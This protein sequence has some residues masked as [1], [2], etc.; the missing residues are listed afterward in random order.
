[1]SMSIERHEKP[2]VSKRFPSSASR[3]WPPILGLADITKPCAVP[4]EP[5]A[6]AHFLHPIKDFM[7]SLDSQA[8]LISI[9]VMMDDLTAGIGW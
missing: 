7:K 3:D 2:A 1:M 9:A 8:G 6:S 5:V 4:G